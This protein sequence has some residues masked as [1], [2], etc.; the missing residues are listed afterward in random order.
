[1]DREAVIIFEGTKYVLC[2]DVKFTKE[3]FEYLT[4]DDRHRNEIVFIFSLICEGTKSPKWSFEPNGTMALKPFLN[5]ENDRILCNTC[6]RKEQKK[7]IVMSE[8]FYSKKTNNI[9][10]TLKNRYKIVSKYNYVIL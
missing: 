2:C 4:I 1:M 6:K 8:F 5:N 10:K 7:C 3:F 9:N